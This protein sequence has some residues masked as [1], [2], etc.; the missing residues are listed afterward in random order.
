MATSS[1]ERR[2]L[3]TEIWADGRSTRGLC[4]TSQI[5]VYPASLCSFSCAD[6]A[7]GFSSNKRATIAESRYART[8]TINPFWK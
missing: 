2:L 8:L 1:E 4:C 7:I 6:H 3:R 5:A